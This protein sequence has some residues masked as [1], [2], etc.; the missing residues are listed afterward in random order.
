MAS[1]PTMRRSPGEIDQ[2]ALIEVRAARNSA[3]HGTIP[4]SRTCYGDLDEQIVIRIESAHKTWAAQE[5]SMPSPC[6]TGSAGADSPDEL[7]SLASHDIVSDT[8][9]CQAHVLPLTQLATDVSSANS[10]VINLK[11]SDFTVIR[12]LLCRLLRSRVDLDF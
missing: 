12:V 3:R 4:A 1:V 2:A 5:Q 7:P 9:R 10:R 6:F 8:A 11:I